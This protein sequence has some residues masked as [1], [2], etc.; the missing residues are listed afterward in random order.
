[1]MPFWMEIPSGSIKRDAILAALDELLVHD[2]A[3]GRHD[4][5]IAVIL[6]TARAQIADQIAVIG[7]VIADAFRIQQADIGEGLLL[8]DIGGG[9]HGLRAGGGGKRQRARQQPAGLGE[10]TSWKIPYFNNPA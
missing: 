9:G 2:G 5:D 1:M 8:G 3:V 4:G 6:R 10:E 7:R